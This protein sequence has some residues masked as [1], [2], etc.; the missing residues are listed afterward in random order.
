MREKKFLKLC[1]KL[2]KM[3][4][5]ILIP[6]YNYDVNSLVNELH[7]QCKALNIDFE[8]VLVDDCSK[9]K[10][11]IENQKL[12]SL[13]NTTYEGL[14]ENIGRSKIRNYLLQSATYEN[15]LI[16][17]CDV[18]IVSSNFIKKYLD[19]IC[20][21]CVIVGGHMYQKDPPKDTSKLLHWKYGSQVE[22]ELL[23]KR[24]KK[25]YDSFMTNNFLIQKKTFNKVK[26]DESLIKYGHEDTLFGIELELNGNYIK[27]IENPV[28][29]LGLKNAKEFLRG[30]KEA[31]S[32]L[33]FLSKKV[34]FKEMILK[35][36]K[37][38]SFENS[39]LLKTYYSTISW[40]YKK[41]LYKML[42]S[43]KPSLKT[44]NF[45][46]FYTLQKLRKLN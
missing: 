41:R 36:S 18:A 25:P 46:K 28:I 17:D 3:S 33:I 5:S 1:N 31:I 29:H 22:C 2:V 4:L 21:E 7:L 42:L 14:K 24:K 44:L 35:K 30:E 27:H 26:F 32:N 39:F 43:E 20:D 15:C 40:Y 16:L 34:K 45:W 37:L 8:I 19:A 11:H 13:S 12:V 38:L 10:F 6:I 23:D 9:S